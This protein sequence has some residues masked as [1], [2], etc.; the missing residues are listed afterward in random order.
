MVFTVF[1]LAYIQDKDILKYSN[2]DPDNFAVL[3]VIVDDEATQELH[4]LESLFNSIGDWITRNLEFQ[5]PRVPLESIHRIAY[6]S[7]GF[8]SD[9]IDV[10]HF[11][12]LISVRSESNPSAIRKI[13]ELLQ[14]KDQFL[15]MEMIEKKMIQLK[16]EDD[17]VGG[18]DSAVSDTITRDLELEN[19]SLAL[20][21]K[22]LVHNMEQLQFK[23]LELQE[24]IAQSEYFHD[25]RASRSVDGSDDDDEKMAL[26][27]KLRDMEL[28]LAEALEN[29]QPGISHSD[30][31]ALLEE[32]LSKKDSII[33]D[34]HDQLD[35]LRSAAEKAQQMEMTLAKYK[36]KV[37]FAVDYKKKFQAAQE[38]IA[39]HVSRID[40]LSE[41]LRQFP[42]VINSY[43]NQVVQLET[44][45]SSL[46]ADLEQAQ[47]Q[48]IK[49]EQELEAAM[50]G[51]TQDQER[52]SE[53]TEKL[54]QIELNAIIG[55][56]YYFWHVKK[57]HRKS[58]GLSETPEEDDD[59]N[60]EGM[61]ELSNNQ[62][63]K[64][65]ADLTLKVDALQAEKRDLSDKLLLST[66]RLED[67]E[68]LKSAFENDY[69][70]TQD[71]LGQ[72][73]RKC[74]SI[75]HKLSTLSNASQLESRLQD[76]ERLLSDALTLNSDQTAQLE[77]YKKSAIDAQL[78]SQSQVAQVNKLLLEKETLGSHV[79]TLSIKVSELER[80]IR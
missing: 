74:A 30:R 38:T 46:S 9:L 67:I 1:L 62:V 52:L 75:E 39:E 5:N 31:I 11:L 80:I 28:K 66:H 77:M 43:K 8:T 27:A 51:K 73:Q 13:Q 35:A 34:L 45:T 72:S 40:S 64:Q 19:R 21:V 65:L 44:K 68:R 18:H 57:A 41:D 32:T 3:P 63:K 22:E 29:A 56:T 10:C 61:Q 54:R 69:R 17:K 6:K 79:S 26:R 23:N 78:Q 70:R 71:L 47:S 37:S 33:Q 60:V 4:D 53:L 59:G 36:K 25:K 20:Q 16:E 50:E 49:V 7:P 42:V 58:S 48:L 55:E 2:S 14:A 24:Q 12:L 76:N 15:I